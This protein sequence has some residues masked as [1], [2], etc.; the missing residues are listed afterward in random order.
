MLWK[1]SCL[2]P[3]PEK[4]PSF[5]NDYSAVVLILHVMKVLADLKPQVTPSVHLDS[6][7]YWK[8]NTEVVYRKGMSRL[9]FMRKLRSFNVC[10]KVFEIFYQSCI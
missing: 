9:Y 8:G 1:T 4:A 6:M 7:L 5:L 2:L 3:V 10:C